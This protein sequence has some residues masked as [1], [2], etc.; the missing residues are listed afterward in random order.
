MANV[1]ILDAAVGLPQAPSPAAS[2]KGA[3]PAFA[4]ALA[5]V[6]PTLPEGAFNLPDPT[7]LFDALGLDPASAVALENLQ[8]LNLTP[9][10]LQALNVTPEVLQALTAALVATE[11]TAGLPEVP[12]DPADVLR[13]MIDTLNAA[14]ACLLPG[15]T[16]V[17]QPESGA[18]QVAENASPEAQILTEALPGFL[19]TPS[20]GTNAPHSPEGVAAPLDA[21][22]VETPSNGLENAAP[23][24][25]AQTSSP[26]DVPAEAAEF[27]PEMASPDAVRLSQDAAPPVQPVQP[28]PDRI[29]VD[30]EKTEAAVSV[31]VA[32]GEKPEEAAVAAPPDSPAAVLNPA[33]V[34]AAPEVQ[35]AVVPV[36][37]DPA[38]RREALAARVA[39]LEALHSEPGQTAALAADEVD[40]L[41]Q[42]SGADQERV[43]A[44]IS[45]A[46]RQNAAG[47]RTTI[48]LRLYPPQL[49]TVRI[50]IQSVRG[51][52]TA[53]IETS[54]PAAERILG[55]NVASLRSDIR[56]TG[57]DLRSVEVSYRNP[58]AQFGFDHREPGRDSY[59]DGRSPAKDRN[60]TVQNAEPQPE[61]L[62]AATPGA[63]N[64]FL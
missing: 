19:E 42:T 10:I 46:I 5:A 45:A 8:A 34:A 29:T 53:R 54:T 2:V 20:A 38:A 58:A 36:D 9:E 60:E 47:E 16:V 41:S 35:A 30:V 59:S 31:S 7:A 14:A 15:E 61:S 6:G 50:R 43:I 55:S 63:L 39:P 44:R 24:P 18:P 51:V 13:R 12:G 64:L 3:G 37:L 28:A 32:A 4:Q 27:A 40:P 21:P 56:S 26:Q 62:V 49:G 17:V 57:V 23:V 11:A 25:V 22:T 33:V 52:L 48:R 1:T